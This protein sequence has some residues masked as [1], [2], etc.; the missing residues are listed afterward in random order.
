[1]AITIPVVKGKMLGTEFMLGSM[2]WAA[3]DRQVLPPDDEHWNDILGNVEETQRKLN[4]SRVKNALVP[5]LLKNSDAFFSSITLV[6]VPMDG[7]PLQEG[8]DYTFAGEE[9]RIE[10]HVLLFPA[11]GQHRRAAIAEAL[12][13]APKYALERV[14]VVLLPYKGKEVI[15]Q[16][17]ADLNLNAKPVNKTIGLAFETRDPLVILTKRVIQ[18]VE[19]FKSDGRVNLVSNSLSAR[20]PA[21]IS[22]NT[23]MACNVELLAALYGISSNED[24]LRREVDDVSDL[25]HMLPTA[26][27]VAPLA[28]KLVE[29]W[30]AIVEH[31]PGWH[32]VMAAHKTP[33]AVR[34]Q[35]VS[36]FGIGWQAIAV[37][38]AAI[39]R[40]GVSSPINTLASCLTRVAWEKGPHWDGIAMVGTRVNNTGPGIRTTAGYI[41]ECGKFPK[42]NKMVDELYALL[43]NSRSS[44]A[45]RLPSAAA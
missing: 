41:L 34:E 29:I 19:L 14:P 33:G 8:R 32:D 10:D 44:G 15:R 45:A 18:E 39:V 13:E 2:T 17:F 16:L 38:A 36:A 40:S 23:L 4:T 43:T 42:G 28:M 31:T 35:Y 6:M 37:A 1:M 24:T 9:L 26:P 3:M 11:D 7:S 21:V 25:A 30:D 27:E 22:M 20:S 5:Y 12:K